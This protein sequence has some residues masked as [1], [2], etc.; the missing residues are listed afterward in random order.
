[1]AKDIGKAEFMFD[2]SDT[3]SMAEIHSEDFKEICVCV[4]KLEV[5]VFSYNSY[6]LLNVLLNAE[7]KS[8]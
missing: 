8:S 3:K 2:S 1:M 7:I 5:P 6:L 4:L